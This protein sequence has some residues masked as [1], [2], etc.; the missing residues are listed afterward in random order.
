MI[1]ETFVGPWSWFR[2]IEAGAASINS[3]LGVA[4][5]A[6]SYEAGTVRLQFEASVRHNPL[7][8]GFFS[9]INIS[10]SLFSDGPS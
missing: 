8:P 7:A 5:V 4:E 9:E 10:D 2:F 3:S 6:L 1:N